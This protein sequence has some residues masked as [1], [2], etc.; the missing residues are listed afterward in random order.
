M[1][2]VLLAA[3]CDPSA[4]ADDAG[5]RADDDGA[6]D[7]D[8]DA[9]ADAGPPIDPSAMLFD[10][11]VIRTYD[12][13]VAP[14]DWSWLKEHARDEVYVPATLTLEGELVDGAVRFKGS[15]STLQSCFDGAGEQTCP[16]LSLKLSFNEVDPDAK[17]HGVRKLNLHAMDH[18]PT[19]MHEAIGY[20]LFRGAG[21][22]AP[23]TAYARVVV[24]GESLGLFLAVENVDGRFTRRTFADGGEGNLYKEV[25]PT[26]TSDPDDYVA[27]LV[28][29]EDDPGVSVERIVRFADALEDAGD[30]GFA[31]TLAAW[32]D[33]DELMAY[34]AVARMIDSWDD[35]VAWYCYGSGCFNHNFYWYEHTDRDRVSLI[36]WDL[37]NSFQE[38]SPMRD[39]YGI[40]D[41]DDLDASCDWID[42]GGG[43]VQGRAPSCDPLLRGIVSHYWAEYAAASQALIDGAFA[44]A[45]VE[46][47]VD[48]LAALIGEEVAADPVLEPA[49]WSSAVATL[50]DV[51]DAKRAYIAAKL[52]P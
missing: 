5:P 3:A 15:W 16:K 49:V 35:V 2:A 17:F 10:E 34:F 52:A 37:D 13:A 30:A 47:R 36:A 48:A 40:P 8:D 27:K 39:A 33:L 25:W 41:W 22:P 44:P 38:P 29:N 6:P 50:R 12:L 19:K 4:G 21:A 7:D 43:S 26:T 51:V 31:A 46:A 28:T 24:N 32:V 1:T 9:P 11:S 20:A 18:D 14:A 23:R 45:A 42:M